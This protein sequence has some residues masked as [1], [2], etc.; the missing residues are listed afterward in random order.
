MTELQLEK[1]MNRITYKP[2][3]R[4]NTRIRYGSVE[5]QIIGHVTD[6][7][8]H[9]KTTDVISE[10]RQKVEYFKTFSIFKEWIFANLMYWES[11]ETYEWFYID[12]KKEHDPHT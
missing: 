10:V 6:V 7:N 12:G 8:D 5:V 4:F 3:F 2:N 9:S 11:H 1:W